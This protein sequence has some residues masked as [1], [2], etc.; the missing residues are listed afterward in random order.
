MTPARHLTQSKNL[1]DRYTGARP[2]QARARTR[3][4]G[5]GVFAGC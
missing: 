4:P 1:I 2:R 5:D 3:A